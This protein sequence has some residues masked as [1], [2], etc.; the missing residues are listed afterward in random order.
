MTV[1]AYLRVSTEEQAREGLS[2]AVQEDACRRA[3]LADGATSV[4]V[5]SDP[6]YSGSSTDRPALQELLRDLA[7]Y[8][9]IYLWRLDRL[10][11]RLLDQV[12]LARRFVDSGVRL[13][14]VTDAVDYSTAEGRLHL[15]LRA[16]VAE[17]EVEQVR[18]R[19]RAALE[20]RAQQGYYHGAD[21]P[22]GYARVRGEDGRPIA[23]RPLVIVPDEARLVRRL[24]RAYAQGAS[25]KH[26]AQQLQA[27]GVTGRRGGGWHASRVR[28]ILTNPAYLGMVRYRGELYEGLHDAIIGAQ[29][30]ATVQERRKR[31]ATVHP[32]SREGSLG[33][34]LRCGD[35]G[36][37]MVLST[38][39]GYTCYYCGQRYRYPQ[40]QRHPFFSKSAAKIA[41]TIWAYV[42]ELY[43]EEVLARAAER[44]RE[45]QRQRQKGGKRARLRERLA[46]LDRQ[47]SYNLEAARAGGI[48]VALLAAENAPLFA[49]RDRLREELAGMTAEPLT[50]VD[51]RRLRGVSEATL[52]GIAESEDV[53]KQREFLERIFTHIEVQREL[54]VFHHRI[55]LPVCERE[56]A[57]RMGS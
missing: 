40:E 15:H 6:G 52:E 37:R 7:D 29:L 33:P 14:S 16:S 18:L 50:A 48:D 24:F 56:Y 32:R 53:G 42:R 23:S 30:W 36:G 1:A 41:R 27:E 8:Q 22:L 57:A 47:V 25:F 21:A 44:Y 20:H 5:Y 38:S 17:Y 11:R 34:L 46:E 26:L 55:T 39:R 19:T 49:E 43:S 51:L 45:A 13:V 54:L 2:L 10:S 4:R 31:R 28:R 9:A 12:T 3:A 35:C